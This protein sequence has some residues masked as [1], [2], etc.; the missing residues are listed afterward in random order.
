MKTKNG[1]HVH[2]R[3]AD[4][5]NDIFGSRGFYCIAVDQYS[6]SYVFLTSPANLLK[7]IQT[8][9]ESLHPESLNKLNELH[10]KEDD[11]Y[12]LVMLKM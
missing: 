12:V 10:L 11:N 5:K 3:K 9:P 8:K 7:I 6:N 4:L 1:T 2:L